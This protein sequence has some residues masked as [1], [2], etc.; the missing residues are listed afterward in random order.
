VVAALLVLAAMSA[1]VAAQDATWPR[2]VQVLGGSLIVYQPQPEGLNGN[3]LTGRAAAQYAPDDGEPIFGTLWF[4]SRIDADKEAGTALVRDITVTR[5]RWPDVTDASEEE[6]TTYLTQTFASVELPISYERLSS[7]LAG[8]EV[9]REGL[10]DLNNDPP[11][12]IV[13]NELSELLQ[14]DGQ[15]R[16]VDIPDTDLEHIANA[17][18]AVVRDKRSGTVYLSG[19]KLW[20]SAPDPMGPWTPIGAPP[21]EI[22]SIVPPDTTDV[23]APSPAPAIVTAS[24]PTEL[25]VTTGEPQWAPIGSGELLYVTNTETP[26]VRDVNAGQI[27]LL[28]S[29]RWY[30][31]TSLDGPWTFAR[32][33]QLPQSF[34]TI[35]PESDLGGVRVSV[36]G[37]QEAEDAVLDAQ[38]PQTT[39]IDRSQ[40]RLEVTYDGDPQ[41]V[42]IDGTQVEYAVNTGAQVLR[43]G[44]HYYACDDGVW[45]ESASATGP[46]AVADNVPSAEIAEIPP[47]EPVYNVT[48]VHVYDATPQVVYVGYTPGYLWSFPYYGVPVYGTGWY[49]PPYWGPRFYYPRFPTYGFHV[50]YNPWTGWSMGFSWSVGFMHVGVSFGGG[51][52]GYRRPGWGPYGWRGGYYPPGGYRRP[53]VVNNNTTNINIGNRGG[54]TVNIGDR[55]NIYTRGDNATRNASQ[56]LRDQSRPTDR[57]RADRTAPGPNNVLSDREGNVYRRNDNGSWDSREG[58][59]WR[60]TSPEA[61]AGTG[62]RPTAPATRPATPDTR[63]AI[64]N[65]SRPATRPAPSGVQRDYGSRVRG[66]SRAGAAA[67]PRGA[68]GRR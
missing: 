30:R 4:T 11:V 56:A 49:Y 7:S 63:P 36:A 38:V 33:D 29:G 68:R 10:E 47:S 41:F 34:Q 24:E 6:V 9:R 67:Q 3:E 31:S 39:A 65:N 44:A 45:F 28:V 50:A 48:H 19:G 17:P 54:N 53:I 21:A 32:G 2:E 66:A 42:H 59:E 57:V 15:P 18:Y 60:P 1:P 46:W 62:A 43:I 35:E 13:V 22:S 37:T 58:R 51:Y 23:P 20:Y 25:V 12:I 26:L 55:N 14:Y 61:G 5:A 27:Y 16:G 52:G 64:P 40:A 8:A